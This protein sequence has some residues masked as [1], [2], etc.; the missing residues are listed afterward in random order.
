MEK[1]G[2]E[3]TL[4]LAQIVNFVIIMFVLTKLLYRPILAILE[5]R[6][7][8]IEEGIRLTAKAREDEQKMEEKRE[9]LLAT[10]RR[11]AQAILEDGRKQ[12]KEEEKEIID[13]ARKE[14]ENIV[15]KGKD[16]VAALRIEMEKSVKQSA[17]E[18]AV[19]MTR[20]LVSR[21]LSVQDQH[22]LIQKHLKD[23]E[24]MSVS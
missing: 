16:D 8:E 12:A 4:L 13:A 24:T 1:L 10:S 17:V 6:K 19:V 9:R 2:I 5:K 23:I 11:E 20:R 14:A 22:K 15:Q 3:P 7:K 21:I 18:L